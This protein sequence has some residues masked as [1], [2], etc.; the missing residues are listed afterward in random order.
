MGVKTRTAYLKITIVNNNSNNNNNNDNNSNSN[1]NNDDDNNN[2]NNNNS[3]NNNNND[4]NNS[5]DNKNNHCTQRRNLRFFT[6]SSLRRE[7]I[8]SSGPGAVVC[9]SYATHRALITCNMSCYMP[10]GT[11]GQLNCSV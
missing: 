8:H 7:H 1:S 3:N 2:N 10:H 6:I 5:N 4:N 11:K 9:R